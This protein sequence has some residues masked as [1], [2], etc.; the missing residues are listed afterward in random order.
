[1]RQTRDS[2]RERYDVVVV[3]AGTSGA[4][5]ALFQAQA[6]RRVALLDARPLQRAGARWVNSV[7]PWMFDRAG[8]ERPRPPEKLDGAS[9]VTLMGGAPGARLRLPPVELLGVDIRLLVRRLQ[10]D[11]SAAGTEN[12]GSARLLDMEHDGERPTALT[13]S[14]PNGHGRPRRV[15]FRARL[16]VDATGLRGAVLRRVPALSRDCPAPGP[17]DVC[18][19]AQAVCQVRDPAGARRFVE[20]FGARP[21]ESLSWIG[22]DGGYSTTGM[23][24]ETTLARVGLLTGTIDDGVHGPGTVLLRRF[25]ADKPWIGR[26]LFGGTGRIPLRRPFA[27]LG[28]PGIALVGDAGCQ[29]FPAHGSGVGSGLIAARELA[30]ATAEADDPGSLEAT[31]QYQARFHRETGAINAAYGL[32]RLLSQSMDQQSVSDMIRAGL[33][34]PDATRHAL[35]QRLPAAGP[36]SLLRMVRGVAKRPD[37][38]R[39]V[40]PFVARIP[41]VYA[42]YRAYP[43]RP[44]FP[45]LRR[46]ARLVARLM[47]TPTDLS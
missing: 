3:G 29:V 23:H 45:A 7:P 31:W 16:F 17:Q 32:L 28:A 19:A 25:L 15:R 46:W 44:D 14:V 13:A 18:S 22:I 39:R 43:L 36:D 33:V 11:A 9:A 5:A 20:G 21:G 6:G 41:L 27:R 26:V 30:D 1:M 35:A 38:T 10:D 42:A 37:L 4:A 8:L 40:L 34:T 12:F 24:L 47:G 2:A